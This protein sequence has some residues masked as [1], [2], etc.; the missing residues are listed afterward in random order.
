MDVKMKLSE[1]IRLGS[2]MKPQGFGSAS[3]NPFADKVCVLGAAGCAAEIDFENYNT[4]YTRLADL[5]PILLEKVANLPIE[6]L[7]LMSNLGPYDVQTIMWYLNDIK[8]WT[9]E[10]I[11]DWVELCEEEYE[12]C[13]DPKEAV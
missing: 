3:I 7:T 2:K 8:K 4:Q 6:G 1:A 12:N 5:W 11:A 13:P 10:Q 9:R